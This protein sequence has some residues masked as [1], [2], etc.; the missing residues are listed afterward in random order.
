EFNTSD[1]DSVLR[2]YKHCFVNF[3]YLS[4]LSDEMCDLLVQNNILQQ[5][6]AMLELF[7]LP[8]ETWS[9][10]KVTDK[11]LTLNLYIDCFNLLTNL[12][13][14]FQNCKY[15]PFSNFSFFYSGGSSK[16][17]EALL[18]HSKIVD[19]LRKGFQTLLE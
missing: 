5:I 17:V 15:L 6:M 3:S 13:Y 9:Q 7:F 11:K 16:F 1:Y 10:P 14:P 8:I 18:S 12:W 4:S 19:V 2:A